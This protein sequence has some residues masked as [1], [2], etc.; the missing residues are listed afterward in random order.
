MRPQSQFDLGMPVKFAGNGSEKSLAD[1]MAL[2]TTAAELEH[3]LNCRVYLQPQ[4]LK[5]LSASVDV[6]ARSL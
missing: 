6:A 2:M 5:P 1:C 4:S 3:L